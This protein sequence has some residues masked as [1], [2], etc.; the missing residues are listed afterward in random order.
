MVAQKGKITC[1]NCLHHH[2]I[3]YTIRKT[4]PCNKLLFSCENENI[5][6]KFDTLNILAQNID[7]G[8][9]L[10]PPRRGGS[11]EY[12][13]PMVWNRNKK[14]CI[15]GQIGYCTGGN[16]NIHIWAWS[17]SPSVRRNVELSQPRPLSHI[18]R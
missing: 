16:F 6:R 13:Q 3:L 18:Y 10:E 15:I 11:N 14:I 2:G 5:N 4:C 7:C 1:T 12:P 17:A 9:T 8:Y